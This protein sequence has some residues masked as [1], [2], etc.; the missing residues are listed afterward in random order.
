MYRHRNYFLIDGRERQTFRCKTCSCELS[1]YRKRNQ[2][3]S[4]DDNYETEFMEAIER[5]R[6]EKRSMD[7]LQGIGTRSMEIRSDKRRNGL[8]SKSEFI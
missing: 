6:N 8:E 2:E 3:W 4:L 5:S 7:G 1:F